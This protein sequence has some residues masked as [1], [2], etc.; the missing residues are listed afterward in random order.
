MRLGQTE[1][2][3]LGPGK[4]RAI[5]EGSQ[6]EV[7]GLGLCPGLSPRHSTPFLNRPLTQLQ[8]QPDI[9]RDICCKEIES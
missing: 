4:T 6:E 3:V 1:D 2:M 7:R 8:A 5:Q 9:S